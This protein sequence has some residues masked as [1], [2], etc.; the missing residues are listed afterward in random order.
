M[1]SILLDHSIDEVAMRPTSKPD[2][3]RWSRRTAPAATVATVVTSAVHAPA[4]RH[5]TGPRHGDDM[6][7]FSN[8]QPEPTPTPAPPRPATVQRHL[9]RE[10]ADAV[11][12][13]L[14]ANDGLAPRPAAGHRIPRDIDHP[15]VPDVLLYPDHGAEQ[16]AAHLAA[17]GIYTELFPNIGGEHAVA[18]ALAPIAAILDEQNVEASL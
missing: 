15:A 7:D 2:R 14:R 5:L 8:I 10:S 13:F 1:P 9:R 18:L 6:L 11:L 4:A 17:I 12:A 16:L 3:H